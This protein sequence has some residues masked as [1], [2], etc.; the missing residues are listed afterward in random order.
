MIA[1]SAPALQGFAPSGPPPATETWNLVRISA[2]S[3][4]Q[5]M[6]LD[7]VLAE[8]VW[9]GHRPPTVRLYTWRQAALTIGRH[10]YPESLPCLAVRRPTGG[11]AV[12]HEDELT[13]SV[14]LPSGHRWLSRGL[15]GSYRHIAGRI[16]AALELLGLPVSI[17]APAPSGRAVD[18]FAC[19]AARASDEPAVDGHKVAAIA[20]RFTPG[21][22]LV[23]AT[24][25]LSPPRTLPGATAQPVSGLR[26]FLPGISEERLANAMMAAFQD[27]ELIL[28]P[29]TVS[30][31]E[32]RLARRLARTRYA[33]CAVCR[34]GTNPH[35]PRL[36]L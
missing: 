7:H 31:E 21:G 33:P 11:R 26:R 9:R 14:A 30:A 18:R 10:Q 5:Q 4:A 36:S 19:F 8:S 29:S 3:A 27:E 15:R 1:S 2:P 24:L 16:H 13:L 34:P 23:Q 6:A 17:D 32:R 28:H 12:F 25:P 22:L 35:T 20:Q